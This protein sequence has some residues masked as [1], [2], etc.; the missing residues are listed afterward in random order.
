M[1]GEPDP[2]Q[3]SEARIKEESISEAM[4]ARCETVLNV[5]CSELDRVH[6]ERVEDWA[7]IGK[8]VLDAEIEKHEQVS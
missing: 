4:A 6:R 7:S 2:L 8:S 5:T 1:T 3:D